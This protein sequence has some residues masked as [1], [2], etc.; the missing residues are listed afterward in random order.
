MGVPKTPTALLARHKIGVLPRVFSR[1]R[2]DIPGRIKLL[3]E[4]L[5]RL[6]AITIAQR[7]V[8][9]RT[10]VLVWADQRFNTDK[11]NKSDF[12]GTAQALSDQ[13]ELNAG[14]GSPTNIVDCT[15][16][17]M[18]CVILN[19]ALWRL[20]RSGFDYALLI[21]PD[22]AS[23][24]TQEA[25]EQMLQAICD[26][27]L[28]T[29]VAIDEMRE[30][31]LSGFVQNTIAIWSIEHLLAVGG[32]DL[33]SQTVLPG[34]DGAWLK[35]FNEHE[36]VY[37]YERHGVEESIPLARLIQWFGPEVIAPILPSEPGNYVEPDPET[38]PDEY[39]R[40]VRKFATKETRQAAMLA[41]INRDRD[42]VMSGV[43]KK[44]RSPE[45]FKKV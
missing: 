44:Y 14:P 10:D 5:E 11:K 2:T 41:H 26:G 15:A 22:A 4:L 24:L 7:H 30:N 28:V 38:N 25:V 33:Y 40:N 32:Y 42:F 3:D 17:D 27:A 23:Y 43:M 39:W 1:A 21:S 9:S 16:G 19:R 34:Y 18:N 13:Y 37:F 6:A 8:F 36:G 35:G 20:A 31:V 12:G 45:V 29:G